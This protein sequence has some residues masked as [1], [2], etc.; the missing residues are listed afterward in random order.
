MTSRFAFELVTNDVGIEAASQNVAQQEH[1]DFLII[2]ELPDIF[3]RRYLRSMPRKLLIRK[4]YKEI[5][6][7]V[8]ENMLR[9][10]DRLPTFLLSGVP[11]IGTSMFLIYFLY[12]F[13]H[14]DRFPDKRFALEFSRGKYYYFQPITWLQGQFV[15]IGEVTS[16]WL[17]L[18]DIPVFSDIQGTTEPGSHCK[19]LFIFSSPNPLR[20]KYI[21]KAAN[22]WTYTVPTWTH[23]ELSLLSPD[24]SQWIDR[25]TLFGG[26]PR[27]VFWPLGVGQ[28]ITEDLMR[29]IA[30]NGQHAMNHFF[31]AGY[32]TLDYR[33]EDTFLLIHVNPPLLQAGQYH[34]NY[35]R[36]ES[37][38]SDEIFKL[39]LAKHALPKPMHL[40]YIDTVSESA[41]DFFKKLCLWFRPLADR[42]LLIQSLAAA[43]GGGDATPAVATV[44]CRL[45]HVPNKIEVLNYHWKANKIGD[46]QAGVLYQPRFSNV[47]FEDSACFTLIPMVLDN[48]QR[49]D[50]TE[51]KPLFQLIV[52]VITA[53]EKHPIAASQLQAIMLSYPKELQEH[54]YE[55]LI[56]FVTPE[57]GIL[58]DEQPFQTQDATSEVAVH[59]NI[60]P[61]LADRGFKQFVCRYSLK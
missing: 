45:I 33:D 31:K 38:A 15:E 12:R 5:Y 41:E 56:V 9:C 6:A 8:S 49:K 50:Q 42:T 53:Q 54:I 3:F 29:A 35:G 40:M 57:V 4:C 27:Y 47:S 59:N 32:S 37:F 61:N 58:R 7:Q 60:M 16:G 10:N 26:V 55:K 46:L 39:V 25:Y 51:T 36:R 28:D 43:G 52:F 22:C 30:W 44:E 24:D 18:V 13:L 17:P 20:F 1:G 19:W 34:V 2:R 14:D 23:G 11:G 21:M 48:D